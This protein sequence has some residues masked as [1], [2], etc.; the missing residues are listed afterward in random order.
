MVKCHDGADAIGLQLRELVGVV[1]DGGLVNLTF[2]GFDARPLNRHT[3]V[4]G[5]EIFY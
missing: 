2:D 4:G 5:V 1:L 3:V